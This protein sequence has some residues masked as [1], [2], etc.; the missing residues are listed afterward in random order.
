MPVVICPAHAGSRRPRA[1]SIDSALRSTLIANRCGR[2][3]GGSWRLERGYSRGTC[4]LPLGSARVDLAGL[5]GRAA[6]GRPCDERFQDFAP[7][8]IGS[9]KPARIGY[10]RVLAAAL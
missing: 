9:H 6:Q 1:G 7:A 10:L 4:L 3:W 5:A 8:A 2:S